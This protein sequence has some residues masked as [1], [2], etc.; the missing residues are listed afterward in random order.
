VAPARS[1][2]PPAHLR[3]YSDYSVLGTAT[4]QRL[5]DEAA[6]QGHTALGLT[7]RDLMTG[8]IE[9]IH[10]CERRGIKPVVGCELAFADVTGALPGGGYLTL[11]AESTAGYHQLL[12]LS[13]ALWAGAPDA[14]HPV[15]EWRLLERH[16][17]GLVVLTG[18]RESTLG[19][20]LVAGDALGARDHLQRLV[21]ALGPDHLYLELQPVEDRPGQWE[22]NDSVVRLADEAGLAVVGT[23]PVRYPSP[24]DARHYQVQLCARTGSTLE[25][26]A[27]LA[28]S[29]QHHLRSPAEL[30]RVFAAWPQALRGTAEVVDR[31]DVRVS[32]VPECR[33]RIPFDRPSASAR[34]RA[35]VRT[36]LPFRYGD[37][38]PAAAIERADHELNII[39]RGGLAGYFLTLHDIVAYA[40]REGTPVSPGR[41]AAAGSIV[42]YCLEVTGIDPLAHGLFFERLLNETTRSLP[43]ADLE[44]AVD[45]VAGVLDHVRG[46]HG[47]DRVARIVTYGRTSPRRAIREAARV[48]GHP[49]ELGNRLAAVVPASVFGRWS[50]LAEILGPGRPLSIATEEETGREIVEGALALEGLPMSASI[51]VCAVVISDRSVREAAPQQRLAD[52]S[53]NEL[54]LQYQR[55]SAEAA[56]LVI[57]DLLGLQVLDLI[58]AIRHRIVSNGRTAT[59]LSELPLDDAHVYEMLAAGDSEGVFLFETADMR[60]VLQ[61]VSP[62]T[63]EDL[64]ALYSLAR[65]GTDHM[66][67]DYAHRKRNPSEVTYVD[68]RLRPILGVSH[69]LL[70]YQ[71]QVMQLAMSIAGFTATRADDM[72]CAVVK[73]D[74]QKAAALRDDFIAGCGRSGTPARGSEEL[75]NLVERSSDWSF[76]R[77]HAVSYVLMSYWTAW[78]KTHFPQEFVEVMREDRRGGLLR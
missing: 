32:L 2:T 34:L 57:F 4:P 66:I 12:E 20:L 5:A 47:A 36:G 54:I 27:I 69:G 24:E 55:Q 48:L 50:S 17:A 23:A 67:A 44:F 21:D 61:L 59:E 30:A 9:F 73:K 63:F 38:A 68:E 51:H 22:L 78:L 46:V 3:A 18:D 33:P 35:L 37:P 7:D 53:E 25:E 14:S 70:L 31:C 13:S 28:T 15:G 16:R 65:P 43:R 75:W 71:E 52:D 76:N 64:L 77:A 74:R 40:R 60:R 58:E 39:E 6:S 42:N 29:G 41:G 45:G 56:G 19:R 11:L 72:R 8:A 10:A 1:L 26:P 49:E 62:T